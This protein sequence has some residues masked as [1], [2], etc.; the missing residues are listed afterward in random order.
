MLNDIKIIKINGK[1]FVSGLMWQP[2][3][4]QRA[5][6]AEAREIG[7]KYGMDI[8]AIRPGA[9]MI[10]AGFV[11]KGNG[12]NKGMYSIASALAGNIQEESWIGAF[13]LPDGNYALVAVHGGMIVPGCDAVGNKQDIRN[14]LIEKDSQRKVISFRKVF[15]PDDFNYRGENL[16]LEGLLRPKQLKADFR[17]K[18]LTFGLTKRELISAGCITIALSIGAV[19][20]FQ[21]AANQERLERQEAARQELLRQ[22]QLADLAAKSASS[23]D[24]QALTHPWAAMPGIEDFLGGCQG[25]IDALPLSLG[26]W[27]F[28]SAICTIETIETV[29]KQAPSATFEM[30]KAA[31][32]SRFPS[33]PVL[34][35]GGDRAGL[36]DQITLGAGGD[37][38]LLLVEDMRSQFTSYFQRLNLPVEII[39][40]A[41]L[42][43]ALAEP[44][45]GQ[46]EQPSPPP[47][48]KSFAFTIT[49][50]YAPETVFRGLSLQGVRLTEISVNKADVQLTWIIK[51]EIYAR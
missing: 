21:W 25:G 28:E 37:D 43:Q 35:S 46:Q 7:K 15:H 33:P 42:A 17:L 16:D 6:M 32:A 23:P 24:A 45:P 31:A 51:G 13:E 10:Q 1:D 29:Y 26:G 18:Q 11:K 47:A 50:D 5:H 30:F 49:T 22:Q 14:L 36:G 4:R 2:L 38:E 12:V 8:V 41:A 9:E 34:L 27:V 39:E 40:N 20:Y 3:Q 44:L 48:W 19:G